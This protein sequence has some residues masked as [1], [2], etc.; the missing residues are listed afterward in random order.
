MCLSYEMEEAAIHQVPGGKYFEVAC[1]YKVAP[2][3]IQKPWRG[4]AC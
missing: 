3:I 4:P 1:V 2:R